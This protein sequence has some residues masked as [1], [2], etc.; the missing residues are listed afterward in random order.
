MFVVTRTHTLFAVFFGT[1]EF[2]DNLK[3]ITHFNKKGKSNCYSMQQH[4]VLKR[5]SII[6]D[7]KLHFRRNVWFV[8]FLC[9]F[10]H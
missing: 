9:Y 4:K 2:F 10:L 3:N 8:R 1:R 5:H 6:V 7:K